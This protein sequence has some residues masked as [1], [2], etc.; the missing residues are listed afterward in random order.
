MRIGGLQKFSLIDYPDKICAIVFTQ[1][2]N[3]RC[4]FCHNP[5][6]VNPELFQGLIP[7][8]DVLS[9]LERRKGKLDAVQITG[10]EPTLQPDIIDF[11]RKIKELDFLVKLD[12]NGS[13][14]E[15][16]KR[17]IELEAVD[18]LAMDVKAPLERYRE[19]TKSRVDPDKIK[20]SIDLV[21]AAGLDYELRTTVVRSLLSPDD[22]LEIGRMIS[23]AR[24]YVLQKFV[25]SKTLDPKFIRETTYSDEEFEHLKKALKSYVVECIVR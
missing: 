17:L 23:G 20:Q 18:Y 21:M 14:P 6:L 9:F 4:S 13:N 15:V 3:F 11:I 2:C 1:G 7:E 19:V 10:G 16:L 12:S 24:L 5:E 22:V 25:G 8:A